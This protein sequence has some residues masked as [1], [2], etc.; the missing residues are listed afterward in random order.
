MT[1]ITAHSNAGSA[2]H[3]AR[4][5]IKP[6][7]SW[8][9]VWFISTAPRQEQLIFFFS[10]FF[11]FFF[12]L[13]RTRGI[14]KF[15]GQGSNRSCSCW[16]TPQTQQY[17]IQAASVTCIIAHGNVRSLTHWARPGVEPMSSWILIKFVTPEPW[18]NRH[19]FFLNPKILYAVGTTWDSPDIYSYFCFQFSFFSISTYVPLLC[20][21]F[22]ELW[23][24]LVLEFVFWTETLL[25]CLVSYSV[26]F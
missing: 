22:Y 25:P 7:T 24:K 6:T 18:R 8:F 5:G 10:F 20:W 13:W 9:L 17:G 12:F 19:G 11:F 23:V 16:P 1:Y 3:W 14:W 21:G 2:T 26:A 15:P 4:P